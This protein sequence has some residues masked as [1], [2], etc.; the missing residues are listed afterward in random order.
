MVENGFAFHRHVARECQ[1]DTRCR[2]RIACHM[3]HRMKRNEKKERGRKTRTTTTKKKKT[4]KRGKE[5][6][7]WGRE[8]MVGILQWYLLSSVSR[9]PIIRKLPC[10][11]TTKGRVSKLFYSPVSISLFLSPSHPGTIAAFATFPLDSDTI[12][13]IP[14][15][16]GCCWPRYRFNNAVPDRRSDLDIIGR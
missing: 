11:R 7:G 14:N 10:A 12:H 16:V 9:A 2:S 4:Q 1:A 6:K 15:S 8:K 13:Q 3:R 5:K